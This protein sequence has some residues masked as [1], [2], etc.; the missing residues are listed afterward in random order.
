MG[1]CCK[2]PAMQLSNVPLLKELCNK[3]GFQ[4]ALSRTVDDFINVV[5]IFRKNY[6]TSDS[7]PGI[8]LKD[9]N[10]AAVQNE[11]S[12]IASTFLDEAGNGDRFWFETRAWKEDDDFNYPDNKIRQDIYL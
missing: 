8:E 9:W 1:P 6:K 5:Y 4:C 7:I 12:I 11:L 2:K 10:I 3:L